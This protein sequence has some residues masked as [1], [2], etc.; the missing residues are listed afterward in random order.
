MRLSPEMSHDVTYRT[1]SNEKD[2]ESIFSFDN[3]TL[4]SDVA[5]FDNQLVLIVND[6]NYTKIKVEKIKDRRK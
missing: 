2:G 6:T 4:L 5:R 3:G 1:I